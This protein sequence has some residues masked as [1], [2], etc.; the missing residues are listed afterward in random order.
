MVDLIPNRTSLLPSQLLPALKLRDTKAFRG[1]T[2]LL[3][4]PLTF[5]SRLAAALCP[6]LED[7]R[8]PHPSFQRNVLVTWHP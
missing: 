3:S 5:E 6:I 8:L 7:H 4:L 2:K 1:S